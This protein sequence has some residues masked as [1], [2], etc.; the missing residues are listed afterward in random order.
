VRY[1]VTI[2]DFGGRNGPAGSTPICCVG[3]PGGA[4]VS[5]LVFQP[6]PPG[7]SP[8]GTRPGDGVGLLAVGAT[9]GDTRP[10]PPRPA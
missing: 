5:A 9:D 4:E 7:S 8:S 2:W 3:L 10:A 1:Q 6:D